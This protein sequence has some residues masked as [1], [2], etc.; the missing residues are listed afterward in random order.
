[1]EE[2]GF[3]VIDESWLSGMQGTQNRSAIKQTGLN[4]LVGQSFAREAWNEK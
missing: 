2:C 3:L 4:I 1:M